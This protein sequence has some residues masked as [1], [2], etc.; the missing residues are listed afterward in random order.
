MKHRILAAALF[1]CVT[2]AFAQQANPT[3]APDEATAKLGEEF[4][5]WKF[6]LF[7]HFNIATFNGQEW[8]NGYED[9][10]HLR[11]GQARLRPVGRRRQGRRA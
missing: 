9:P 6:G 7:L 10:G 1:C 8:A 5:R 2:G 4:L 11:A 3:S